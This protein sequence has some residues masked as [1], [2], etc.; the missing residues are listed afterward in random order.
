MTYLFIIIGLSI[1]NGLALTVSHLEL[2]VT[3]LLF[4]I[5]IWPFESNII[6]TRCTET[7]IVLYDKIENVKHGREEE[8]IADLKERTGLD[9]I[10]VEVGHIDFLRDVAFVKVTYKPFNKTQNTIN[11][12]TKLKDFQ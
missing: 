2:G 7:K 3:N 12:I 11:N 8:L 10:E 4:I 1:I 6:T 5:A 9:I